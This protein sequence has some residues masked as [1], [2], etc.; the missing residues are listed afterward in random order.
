VPKKRFAF[1]KYFYFSF[2]MHI[3][4]TI[5]ALRVEFPSMDP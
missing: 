4:L 3:I 1:I 2:D 5:K